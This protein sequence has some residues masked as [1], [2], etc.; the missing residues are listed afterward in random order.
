[1][2]TIAKITPLLFLIIATASCS[3]QQRCQRR[4]AFLE[5]NC[6]DVFTTATIRDTIIQQG[7]SHDTLLIMS[8]DTTQLDTIYVEKERTSVRIVRIH[9][10][11]HTTIT[12]RPDT[13]YRERTVQVA[14]QQSIK[15]SNAAKTLAVVALTLCA[16]ILLLN[17]A[18]KKKK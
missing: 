11:L 12:T 2:K 7:W 9:D 17:F 18:I 8:R 1:M 16:A 4:L 10:T 14:D 3:T 5:K 6:P 13:I 15:K